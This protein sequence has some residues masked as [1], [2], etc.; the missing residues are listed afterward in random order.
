MS[1]LAGLGTVVGGGGLVLTVALLTDEIRGLRRQIATLQRR[2]R[3]RDDEVAGLRRA[4]GKK[5]CQIAL[6]LHVVDEWTRAWQ[7]GG[8]QV[9][10]LPAWEHGF[11][12]GQADLPVAD[13]ADVIS[14]LEQH[15]NSGQ[16]MGPS[17]EDQEQ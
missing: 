3:E 5:D 15:A 17:P 9:E 1:V 12:T 2:L 6:L 7:A 11:L 8:G 10:P 4:G 16:P 14:Q 13:V